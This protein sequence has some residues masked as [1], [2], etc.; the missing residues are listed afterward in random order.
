MPDWEKANCITVG[1]ELF[2]EEGG[3]GARDPNEVRKGVCAYCPIQPECLEQAL[4][5]EDSHGIWG[6]TLPRQ[7]LAILRLRKG[8]PKWKWSQAAAV[9]PMTKKPG[10]CRNGD[11]EMVGDNIRMSSHG[12]PTCRACRRKNQADYKLRQKGYA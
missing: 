1:T 5:T 4:E 6:G 10:L 9:D 12:Y 11:H 2:Y 8:D 3:Q 7:R